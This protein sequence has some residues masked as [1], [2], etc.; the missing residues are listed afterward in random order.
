MCKK[1]KGSRSWIEMTAFHNRIVR[2]TSQCWR[3]S[4]L[5]HLLHPSAALMSGF[6][7]STLSFTFFHFSFCVCQ[8]SDSTTLHLSYQSCSDEG[9]HFTEP[10][11]ADVGEEEEGRK[12]EGV[13]KG[14]Q[15]ETRREIRH[16]LR[17][18]AEMTH[19]CWFNPVLLFLFCRFLTWGMSLD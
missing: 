4:G 1:P 2:K 12:E 16:R 13:R 8:P 6:T 7:D 5:F 17:E 9:L 19:S 3:V 18:K 15:Q 11:T 10:V 14:W